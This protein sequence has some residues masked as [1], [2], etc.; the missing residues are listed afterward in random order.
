MGN[1]GVFGRFAAIRSSFFEVFNRDMS[2]FLVS[3]RDGEAQWY[4]ILEDQ[5]LRPFQL[6]N[7]LW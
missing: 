7:Q 1:Q 3:G 5:V 2:S 6:A 4:G